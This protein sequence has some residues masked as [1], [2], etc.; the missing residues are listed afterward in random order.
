MDLF[1]IEENMSTFNK[2]I[3]ESFRCVLDGLR[4]SRIRDSAHCEEL[5]DTLINAAE[6]KIV[7]AEIIVNVIREQMKWVSPPSRL[8]I[9]K[10]VDS[11][12]SIVGEKYRYLFG[13][14]IL[15]LFTAAFVEADSGIRS[16][17]FKYR[18]CWDYAFSRQVL[19]VLDSY[20]QTLDPNWPIF[21]SRP[22][23]IIEQN[24][25][26]VLL[27]EIHLLKKEHAKMSAEVQEL[28]KYFEKLPTNEYTPETVDVI[29]ARAENVPVQNDA[30]K[31]EK[32]E[33]KEKKLKNEKKANDAKSSKKGKNDQ[34]EKKWKKERN[35]TN[36]KNEK[37]SRTE[38]TGKNENKDK[39]NNTENKENKERNEKRRDSQKRKRDNKKQQEEFKTKW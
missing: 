16:K 14:Y 39:R 18:D 23:K 5:I 33:V 7:F 27:R 4:A 21:A 13:K 26:V 20:V 15:E 1:E 3:A 30:K 17:L 22:D 35:D 38:N 37:K 11:I 24:K 10:L 6:E 12:L 19:H 9:I 29:K 2:N 31:I 28:E 32:K 34:E 25:N 36:R 8:L